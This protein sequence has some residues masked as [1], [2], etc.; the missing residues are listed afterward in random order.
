MQGSKGRRVIGRRRDGG[1][2][3]PA[4]VDDLQETQ[5]R[6]G[7]G[8]RPDI[9]QGRERAAIRKTTPPIPTLAH[10]T[11]LAQ[12]VSERPCLMPGRLDAAVERSQHRAFDVAEHDERQRRR[13]D[14]DQHDVNDQSLGAVG[15]Q[16]KQ[17]ESRE[18]EDETVREVERV[19]R[20]TEGEAR[21]VHGPGGRDKKE[22]SAGHD[23]RCGKAGCDEAW[24]V[25]AV[26]A[27]ECHQTETREQGG[28]DRGMPRST[29]PP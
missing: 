6:R 13:C 17:R 19:G 7:G 27:D 1:I 26:Q 8:E 25:R 18:P 2:F 29:P 14:R 28:A 21:A 24:Q 15:Q 22:N 9:G 10:C 16:G 3:E 5:W 11:A 20:V 23:Q 4:L 12:A